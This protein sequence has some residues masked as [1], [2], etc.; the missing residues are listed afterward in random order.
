MIK[1]P[2]RGAFISETSKEVEKQI[3]RGF[4]MNNIPSVA[5]QLENIKNIISEAL[6]QPIETSAHIMAIAEHIR[7]Y[8]AIKEFTKGHEFRDLILDEFE[9]SDV[10]KEMYLETNDPVL[11]QMARDELGHAE[12]L[13]AMA[14]QKGLDMTEEIKTLH[15]K[16]ASL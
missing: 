14:T 2:S 13:I 16:L 1:A 11:R 6:K 5:Q 10:Y 12:N 8:N 3:D 7:A 4:T 15:E 9:G